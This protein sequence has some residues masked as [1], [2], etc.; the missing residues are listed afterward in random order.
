M[1]VHRYR[2]PSLNGRLTVFDFRGEEE[3]V[4]VKKPADCFSCQGHML[5]KF[6]FFISLQN[7]LFFLAHSI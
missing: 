2:K 3:G 6:F 7:C 5:L 4:R 1:F